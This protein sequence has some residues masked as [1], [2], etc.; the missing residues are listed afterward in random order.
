[1][2]DS[3]LDAR[4]TNFLREKAME[5]ERTIGYRPTYFLGMLESMGGYRTA[6][7]LLAAKDVSDGFAK[8]WEGGRLDLT[9]EALAVESEWRTIFDSELL[10]LAERKL[11]GAKYRFLRWDSANSSGDSRKSGQGLQAGVSSPEKVARPNRIVI[12]WPEGEEHIDVDIDRLGS[13]SEIT[14]TKQNFY[15]EQLPDIYEVASRISTTS[16]GVNVIELLYDRVTNPAIE[17]SLWGTIR[18]LVQS[19]VPNGF[20]TWTDEDD[21]SHNC[22]VA[23]ALVRAATAQVVECWADEDLELAQ[24]SELDETT[25]EVLRRERRGQRLFRERVLLQEPICRLTGVN[26]PPHLRASHIKP[27][28]DC[29][30][31]ERLDANNGLMLAPHVDHLFDRAFISF[32]DDGTLLIANDEI[33][34]IMRHWGLN[35][36]GGLLVR[37]PFTLGQSVYL[38]YHRARFLERVES[39]VNRTE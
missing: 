32:R 33:R 28:A 5:A 17:H 11:A 38:E 21:S 22:N 13:H 24:R 8:L 6:V 20:A 2:I 37:K 10:K 15:D 7:R 23:F 35:P 3:K 16:D 4:F 14:H 12:Y 1:M 34:Q 36:D 29:R 39:E 9:V 26:A 18:I 31:D 19:N 25:K 27:W 30:A